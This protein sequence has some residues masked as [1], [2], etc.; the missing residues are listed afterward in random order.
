MDSLRA[1]FQVAL[2]PY[3]NLPEQGAG[4]YTFVATAFALRAG[5]LVVITFS[6]V[7]AVSWDTAHASWSVSP[8]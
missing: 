1:T 7:E 4:E 3:W 8:H 2:V 6:A 5:F